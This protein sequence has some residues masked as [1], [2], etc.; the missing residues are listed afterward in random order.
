MPACNALA[1]EV[2]RGSAQSKKV[3]KAHFFGTLARESALGKKPPESAARS[4]SVASALPGPRPGGTSA[5]ATVERQLREVGERAVETVE[6]QGWLEPLAERIQRTVAAAFEAGGE[7]GRRIRDA[8]HGTWLGHPLHPVLTDV[9]L[10]AWTVAAALD[11]VGGRGAEAKAADAAVGI[12]L[13]G[14]AGAAVT[15]ITD[16]HHTDG[17]DRRVGLMHGMLNGTATVLYATSLVLRMRGARGAG[18]ATA[19]LGFTLA[20]AAA[21]LG[22]HLVYK[23]R[24]GTDHAPRVDWDDFVAALPDIEL[25]EGRARRVDVHGVAVVLV[26][27]GGHIHALADRCAH[28]GGPLSEGSVDEVSIRCPWHGSRFALEDGRLLEGPSTYAQ[29]CFETR[30]RN[31][32]IEVRPRA[33]S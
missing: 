4:E 18:R 10:G 26:R 33:E 6:R 9:P 5:M 25:A 7:R 13:V 32:H 16:W 1:A 3:G 21:Y 27:R 19:G 22:G 2:T 8:L 11:A 17:D 24:I 30:V 23:R 28:L 15:G 20:L 12:G 14:A 31:G 29:A